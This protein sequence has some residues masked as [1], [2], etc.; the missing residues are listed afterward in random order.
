LAA[1]M[2]GTQPLILALLLQV[3]R[4][5]KL[6]KRHMLGAVVSLA[7]VV[8]LFLDRLH[9]STEQAIGIALVLGSV[10][11]ATS[12]TMVMKKQTTGGL[13]STTVFLGVTALVLSV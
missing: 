8:V 3:F 9:V 4:I 1:V 13:V 2:Y 6:S 7:G 11:M 10:L 5:E 12:Y